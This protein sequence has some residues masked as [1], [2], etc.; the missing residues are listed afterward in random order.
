MTKKGIYR[1]KSLHDNG[2]VL[3]QGK[4]G[5]TLLNNVCNVVTCP[6]TDIDPTIDHTL[7]RP[8][9]NMACEACSSMDEEECMLL[10]DGCG[11]G[12]AYHVSNAQVDKR[13]QRR[14]AVPTMCI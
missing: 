3:L 12:W 4:F 2:S 13:S 14:L 7:A 1:V 5:V 8:D 6:L 10:C 11:T 9:K